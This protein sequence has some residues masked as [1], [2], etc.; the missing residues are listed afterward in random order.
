MSATRTR[1]EDDRCLGPWTA[2]M[3][4]ASPEGS[5]RKRRTDRR[6]LVAFA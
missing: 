4:V 1:S 2:A 6:V 5:G 3:L